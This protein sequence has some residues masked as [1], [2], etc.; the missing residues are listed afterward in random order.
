M[1]DNQD[2][3]VLNGRGFYSYQPGD[4]THWEALL[5]EHAWAVRRLQQRYHPLNAM[6]GNEIDVETPEE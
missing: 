5:H 1:L 4:A 2:R 6:G 3:G